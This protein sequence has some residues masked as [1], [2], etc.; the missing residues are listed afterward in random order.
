MFGDL[1]NKKD[2]IR[3]VSI[4]LGARLFGASGNQAGAMAGKYYLQKQD[5]HEANV[6]AYA[7]SGKYQPSSVAVFEKTRNLADLIAIGTPV[8]PTGT[9]KMF[10]GYDKRGNEVSRR[11]QEFSIGKNHKVWKIKVKD[12]KSGKSYWASFNTEGFTDD[13][14][15]FKS[16][17]SGKNAGYQAKYIALAEKLIKEQTIGKNEDNEEVNYLPGIKPATGGGE[18]AKWSMDNRISLVDSAPIINM[19][20]DMAKQAQAYDKNKQV[21]YLTPYLNKAFVIAKTDKTGVGEVAFQ[22]ADG[23]YIDAGLLNTAILN[24]QA[25]AIKKN[26]DIAM[27][28]PILMQTAIVRN[29]RIEYMRYVDTLKT[30]GKLDK[31]GNFYANDIY[32]KRSKA[33]NTTPLYEFMLEGG[34]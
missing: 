17:E 8:V 9:Y 27:M 10:Y 23:D 1:F 14:T 16:D 5:Q 20:L 24:V 13:G 2:L 29:A 33:Q 32:Y 22:N 12:P 11:A 7:T 6:K 21:K 18:L 26:P 4:Y 31:T 34:I 15:K 3:A 25:A 30:T 28:N 19:A